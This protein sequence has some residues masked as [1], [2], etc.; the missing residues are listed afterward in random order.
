[1]KQVSVDFS[2]TCTV[3]HWT[4]YSYILVTSVRW[5]LEDNALK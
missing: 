2:G 4:R 1:M 5:P 3:H